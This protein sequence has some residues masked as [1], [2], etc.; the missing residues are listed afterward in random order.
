VDR[1]VR[2]DVRDDLRSL[3]VGDRTIGDSFPAPIAFVAVNAWQGLGAAT[4]GALVVGAAVAVWRIRKG[5]Q[6]VYA[7][8]GIV[9]IGFAALIALRS[10]RAEG[11]FLPGIVSAFAWAGVA[12]V[13]LV[14]RK[15]LAAWSS[16]AFRRWPRD[17]YWRPDVRPAY[18]A[19]T[20]IWAAYFAVRGGVQWFFYVNE[21]PELLAVAK[22]ATSWP[23]ILP[24][25]IVSYVYG[26]R[27][28]QRLGGPNVEEF[29]AGSAP[30]Y[31]GLQR[32]F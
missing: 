7:L 6:V 21:Q 1:H 5:Q 13:S 18:A 16:W 3:F 24:L 14:V 30:P 2:D 25:L 4:V 11:Y 10:G 19:V 17:W 27:R 9:A 23:T 32:G 26:N 29:A 31:V 15:P 20:V 12:V 28:L 22:L 8:G